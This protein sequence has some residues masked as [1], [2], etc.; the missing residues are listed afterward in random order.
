[1]LQDLSVFL[2]EKYF[3]WRFLISKASQTAISYMLIAKVKMY[4]KPTKNPRGH[5]DKLT[6]EQ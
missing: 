5:N 6:A 3:K 2:S 4:N 1:M